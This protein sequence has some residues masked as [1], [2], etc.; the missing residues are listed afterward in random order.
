M[1]LLWISVVL[2]SGS[3]RPNA[4][5]L[6]R[7]HHQ[8]RSCAG[9][10]C[11]TVVRSKEGLALLRLLEYF[12]NLELHEAGVLSLEKLLFEIAT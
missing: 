3:F 11:L 12:Y 7:D 4:D 10:L 8:S 2:A 5:G 9:R 6:A 1:L